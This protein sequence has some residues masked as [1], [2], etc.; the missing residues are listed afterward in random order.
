MNTQTDRDEH[1][2]WCKRDALSKLPDVEDAVATFVGDL[3]KHPETR[4]DPSAR[5]AARLK[6]AGPLSIATCRTLIEGTY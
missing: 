4:E 1:L 5:L 6:I 2:A 3:R